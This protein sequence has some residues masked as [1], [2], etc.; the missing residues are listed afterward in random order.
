VLKTDVDLETSSVVANNAMNR[1]RG[2]LGVNSYQR[3]LGF[4]PHAFLSAR[5]AERGR[6]RWLDLCCGE[7]NALIEAAGRFAA[8]AEGVGVGEVEIVGVD[9][10]G[11]FGVDGRMPPGLE[12]VAASVA[13]WTPSGAFDLVTCVHGLHYI[14]DKLAL[15]TRAS[16]WLAADGTFAAD[17]D[18]A[19]IRHADGSPA[20]RRVT[21]ALRDTGADYNSRRHRVTW[22]GP[23]PLAFAARFLGA[24]DAAGPGY[25]GQPAVAASHYA[26]A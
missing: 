26:W 19:A 21:R 9:L 2:L 15:L 22:R 18:P 23:I 5:L 8:G 7:G 24:D 25:T 3:V 13:T 20:T 10:I 4:D 1:E 6:A 16:S 14:G 12:L 17:F 11:R